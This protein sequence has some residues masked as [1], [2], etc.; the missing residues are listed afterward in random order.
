MRNVNRLT[1]PVYS[2]IVTLE[3]VFVNRL[4]GFA[5]LENDRIDNVINMTCK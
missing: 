5:K 4:A 3:E 2:P 1:K